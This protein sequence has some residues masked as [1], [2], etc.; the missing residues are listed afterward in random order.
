MHGVLGAGPVSSHRGLIS[1]IPRNTI[2]TINTTTITTNN[3]MLL[4][5]RRSRSFTYSVADAAGTLPRPSLVKLVPTP[6]LPVYLSAT[7]APL[8]SRRATPLITSFRSYPSLP[9]L[10]RR[11]RLYS[12]GRFYIRDTVTSRS[13][14]TNISPTC[15]CTS[16]TVHPLTNI[17]TYLTSYIPVYLTS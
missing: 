6:V 1:P 16:L 13:L 3:N 10:T 15:Q 12:I 5:I 8:D 14:S 7:A 9:P 4:E 2:A 17:S 11:N